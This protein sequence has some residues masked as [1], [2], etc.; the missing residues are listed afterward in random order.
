MPLVL[1]LKPGERVTVGSRTLRLTHY[2]PNNRVRVET[3]TGTR[4][5][6][7]KSEE[8]EIL[9][10]VWIGLAP[11]DARPGARLTFDAPPEIRIDRVR[12]PAG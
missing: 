6:L 9:A 4:H 1:T 10:K 3:D 2:L 7:N 5:V 11:R 12:Q 8:V